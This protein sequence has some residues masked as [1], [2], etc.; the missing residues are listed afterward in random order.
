MYTVTSNTVRLFIV[1]LNTDIFVRVSRKLLLMGVITGQPSRF[2]FRILN[3]RI[4]GIWVN[5]EFKQ[6][7]FGNG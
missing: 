7:N 3:I 5:F 6:V 1:V 4:Q 2:Y